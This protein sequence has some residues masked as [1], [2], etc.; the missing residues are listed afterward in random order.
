[1]IPHRS[2][3]AAGKAT[4]YQFQTI[5]LAPNWAAP[6]TVDLLHPSTGAVVATITRRVWDAAGSACMNVGGS[7]RCLRADRDGRAFVVL[8]TGE[9]EGAALR[10]DGW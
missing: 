8:Y 3:I 10:G 7:P 9:A 1:M 2:D 5:N 4:I 6:L